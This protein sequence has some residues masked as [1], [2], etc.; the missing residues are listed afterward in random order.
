[1]LHLQAEDLK[2]HA[3]LSEPISKPTFSTLSCDARMDATLSVQHISRLC[4]S[5]GGSQAGKQVTMVISNV[6]LETNTVA[7]SRLWQE[8]H[9]RGDVQQEILGRTG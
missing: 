9:V 6:H 7:E 2:L 8:L 3:N 1:M 4:G 5:S